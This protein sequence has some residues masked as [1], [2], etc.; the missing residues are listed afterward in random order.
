MLFTACN[1]KEE[2]D[3]NDS[4]NNDP[5]N[6]APTCII[7]SPQSDKVFTQ[8]DTIVI[9]VEAD[10]QDSNLYR[11]SFFIEEN[12]IGTVNQLPY[13]YSW[14]TS[15]NDLGAYTIKATAY[16][17]LY[18][19]AS[20]EVVVTI[21]PNVNYGNGVTDIDGNVYNTVIIGEQEWMAENLKVTTYK[22]GT[23]IELLNTGNT[24]FDTTGLYCWYDF[25]EN[26]YA[27]PYGAL[28]D[29]YAVRKDKLCP[30]GWHVAS[31]EDWK[32]LEMELGMIQEEANSEGWRGTNQGS[33]LAGNAQ[34]WNNGALDD[35]FEFGISGFNAL[36]AGS[37]SYYGN[38]TGIGNSAYWWTKTK[39]QEIVGY[40]RTLSSERSQILRSS[41]Y[42]LF[43]SVRCVKD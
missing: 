24:D 13:T 8:G 16:D 38:F 40:Y 42:H 35:D 7:T 32:V 3:N 5:V 30:S 22:D 37:G 43:F 15:Q 2:P 17:D 39:E 31:D 4:V 27:D 19:T 11:I 1:K 12:L 26:S 33:K 14:I 10:D 18:E 9:N 34:L 23:P 21:D 41:I 20:D 25:N 28:Y 36:P 29:F 6:H